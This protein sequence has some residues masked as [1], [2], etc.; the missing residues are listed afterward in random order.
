MLK[1]RIYSKVLITI[2]NYKIWTFSLLFLLFSTLRIWLWKIW[3]W[4]LKP[5]FHIPLPRSLDFF[6]LFF[7]CF[8]FL[9]SYSTIMEANLFKSQFLFVKIPKNIFF[10][11]NVFF[12]Y[13]TCH[14]L[15]QLMSS[16]LKSIWTK[17]LTT[18]AAETGVLPVQRLQLDYSTSMLAVHVSQASSWTCVENG[19]VFWT[20]HSLQSKMNST[21]TRILGWKKSLQDTGCLSPL[22]Q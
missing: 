21:N 22:W 3:N 9:L 12:S 19:V 1:N 17:G 20:K 10:I 8:F 7:S 6:F 2:L 13:K 16:V 15:M 4:C 14:I 5:Y 18:V 11:L